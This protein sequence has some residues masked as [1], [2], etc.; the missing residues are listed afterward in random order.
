MLPKRSMIECPGGW[1]AGRRRCR[2][3]LVTMRK[4]IRATGQTKREQRHCSKIIKRC[5]SAGWLKKP[6]R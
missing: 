6:G 2:R 5:Y 1:A 3:G 4:T